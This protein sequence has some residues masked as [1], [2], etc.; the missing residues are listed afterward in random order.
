LHHQTVKAERNTTAKYQFAQL[1]ISLDR[2]SQQGGGFSVYPGKQKKDATKS[3]YF[4]EQ[5]KAASTP[6]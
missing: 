6:T 5:K 4:C 1:I 2:E 3:G